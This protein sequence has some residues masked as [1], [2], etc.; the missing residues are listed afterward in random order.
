QP[1]GLTA[2]FG[3]IYGAHLGVPIRLLGYSQQE[4]IRSARENTWDVALMLMDSVP[5]EQIEQAG[6]LVAVEVVGLVLGES[7]LQDVMELDRPGLRLAVEAKS[8]V[9]AAAAGKVKHA[10]LV[11]VGSVKKGVQLLK[12]GRADVLVHASQ[13]LATLTN[14]NGGMRLLSGRLLS[15]P[16]MAVV[17]RGR[18]A[19]RSYTE[20]FINENRQS[21]QFR[22]LLE[23]AGLADVG[24]SP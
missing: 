6:Q 23:R 22:Q 24:T 5:D 16:V 9:E 2:E 15:L 13:Q 4:L 8:P 10:A 7:P 3:A 21:P 19:G 20:R 14:A 17:P 18:P 11:P 1:A 12:E